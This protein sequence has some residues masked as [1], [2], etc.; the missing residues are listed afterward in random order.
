MNGPGY[1]RTRERKIVCSRR[2]IFL[3]GRESTVSLCAIAS[4]PASEPTR[5][6]YENGPIRSLITTD[7]TNQNAGF[8]PLTH[9]C[10]RRTRGLANRAVLIFQ[11]FDKFEEF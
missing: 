2:I 7:R 8:R 6:A 9:D 11:N 1:R 3:S 10:R 4:E 5:E